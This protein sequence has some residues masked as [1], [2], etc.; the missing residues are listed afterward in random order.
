MEKPKP[1]LMLPAAPPDDP[2]AIQNKGTATT[3]IYGGD[4]PYELAAGGTV[5]VAW[6]KGRW[7][8]NPHTP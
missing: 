3:T 6:K 2:L 5:I 4:E 8:F 1:A 7:V